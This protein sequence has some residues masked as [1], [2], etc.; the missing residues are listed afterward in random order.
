MSEVFKKFLS[1]YQSFRQKYVDSDKLI[2]KHLA[3]NG[4]QPKAM[5]IACSDSRVDPAIILQCDPGDLFVIRNV[6]SI[7]PPYQNDGRYHGTSA[8]LEFGIRFL[9]IKH[10]ILL[11]HSQCGGMQVL[12]DSQLDNKKS[13]QGDFINSWVSIVKSSKPIEPNIDSYVKEAL[14]KSY[15]NCLTFPWI[16]SKLEDDVLKIHRWFFK[17]NSGEIFS[18]SSNGQYNPLI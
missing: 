4:Q 5:V 18:H 10:L 16:R 8:A 9:N 15:Q 7:V 14:N 2:M 1:G 3:D 6:A 13:E 11:G 17:I 12:M